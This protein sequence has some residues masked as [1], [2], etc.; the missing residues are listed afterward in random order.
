MSI[1]VSVQQAQVPLLKGDTVDHDEIVQVVLSCGGSSWDP[2]S[3][4]GTE[5]DGW[6]QGKKAR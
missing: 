4:G 3:L 6:W 1:L 2:P 5:T